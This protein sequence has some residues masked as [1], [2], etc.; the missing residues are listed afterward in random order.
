MKAFDLAKSIE[1]LR[2]CDGLSIPGRWVWCGS[3]IRG[4]DGK[5]HLFAASWSME[6]P[7]FSGYI[8]SS[9][10]IRAE[11]D[12]PYGPFTY[13]ETVLPDRGAEYW[14]GRMTHNPTIHKFRDTY[15]LF[16][17]GA[18]Y[19]G[20]R[21][22]GETLLQGK[23]PLHDATYSTIRIGVATAKSVHGPWTRLDRPILDISP[24]SWDRLV[25][26][27]PAACFLPDG[28][29]YLYYRCGTPQGLKIG[30][31]KGNADTL[32]FTKYPDSLFPDHPE[33]S[34]EDHFVWHN[35]QNFEMIAK[36]IRGNVTGI[37][38]GGAHFVSRDGLSWQPAENPVAYTRTFLC[39][40]GKERTFYHFERPCL[41][42]EN[43]QPIALYAAL[44]EAG[45]T[46]LPFESPNFA[47]M[48]RT[49]NQAVRLK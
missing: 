32:Q 13:A 34:L 38:W 44:G 35:G 12:T 46:A 6:R 39:E 43:G 47:K 48:L 36:D 30:V 21:P 7:F 42:I 49:K 14:D 8:F 45:E 23:H 26:T 5:Y 1:P 11:S 20:E 28:T 10:I 27:N 40:D 3:A 15:Y 19:E 33:W 31:A 22:S 25:V 18:T 16:Y 24:D 9:E 37:I 17:I 2:E 29:I 4:E 41:L